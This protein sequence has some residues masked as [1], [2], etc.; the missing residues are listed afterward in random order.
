MGI[1]VLNAVPIVMG[2]KITRLSNFPGVRY[3]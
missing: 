3:K 2:A 1:V